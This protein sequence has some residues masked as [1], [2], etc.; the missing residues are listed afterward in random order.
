MTAQDLLDTAIKHLDRDGF[1]E[2][3]T[4]QLNKAVGYARIAQAQALIDLAAAATADKPIP[5][6]PAP[7][8]VTARIVTA[9]G[10]RFNDLR[11]TVDVYDNHAA[12]APCGWTSG[13]SVVSNEVLGEASKH[14]N[15]CMA[16]PHPASL[17]TAIH[18]S[19]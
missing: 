2:L 18:H 6:D 8:G 3:P 13:H 1:T 4:G 12:C 15:T 14:A 16:L 17:N 19:A 11:T 7:D 10:R 9:Y 5:A